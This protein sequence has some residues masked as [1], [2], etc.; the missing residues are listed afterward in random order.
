MILPAMTMYAVSPCVLPSIHYIIYHDGL[1]SGIYSVFKY[2]ILPYAIYN[3][4]RASLY[5]L[6]RCGEET[7]WT[8]LFRYALCEER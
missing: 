6:P 4:R 2:L 7:E 5:L 8:E 1:Q 3:L